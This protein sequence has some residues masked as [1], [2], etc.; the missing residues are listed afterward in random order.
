MSC[1]DKP[2]VQLERVLAR[3]PVPK[4]KYTL[5]RDRLD[6]RDQL[7]EIPKLL[8]RKQLPKRIDLRSSY[9]HVYDQGEL[10]SCTANALALAFD[11]TRTKI[12]LEALQPSRLFLYY[13][14]RALE[15]TINE[16]C[17]AELRT[18]V[19]VCA[20]FGGC[21]EALWP[22][23]ISR[24]T[25]MPSQACFDEAQQHRAKAYL[26]LNNSSER[27]LKACLADGF[28]FACGISVYESFESD[29]VA[30]TGIV[31][32]PDTSTEELFGGHAVTCLGYD[33]DKQWFIMRNSWG[34]AWGDKGHFYIPYKYLTDLSLAAD[35]WT[36][37]TM[38][39][40]QQ[41]TS[42]CCNKRADNELDC[43]CPV[44]KKTR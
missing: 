25:D 22:Y 35:F 26:R 3:R 11:F 37:R 38:T 40:E 10:G 18:G 31:P 4:H 21:T 32:I 24:F 41:K 12:G 8:A 13:N 6:K 42:E 28:T 5:K 16:D 15:N 1:Q 44:V 34:E 14:E 39:D 33:D 27:Q 2:P 19:K 43:E 17:G 9:G 36:L 20:K 7:Y 23:D 30:S 29:K